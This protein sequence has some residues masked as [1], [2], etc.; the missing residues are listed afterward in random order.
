MIAKQSVKRFVVETARDKLEFDPKTG[1]LVSFRAKAVPDQELVQVEEEDPVFVIQ[2]LDEDKRFRQISSQQAEEIDVDCEHHTSEEIR[3][4]EL[5]AKFRNLKRLNI[6]VTVKVQTSSNDRFS[7]WSLSLT[8]KS[9]LLIT[10][11]QFPFIVVPYKLRGTPCSETLLWPFNVGQLLKNPQPEDLE[12]DSPHAWQFR[13]ENGDSDH[14]PGLTFAQFLAYFNDRGGIYISCQDSSGRIKLI[15]PVHHGRGLRLGIAHVGDWPTNGERQ[16]EYKVVLGSFSGDWYDA[17]TLYRDWSL[18]QPWAQ[19]PLHLRE[20]VP[21]WLLDSPPHIILRIQGKLDAGPT[22]PNEEFFPY[23]KAIPLL[24]KV[25]SRLKAPLVPVIMSWENPGPWIYPESLPPVGGEE[26]LREFTELARER[27]WHI[28]T[29]CNGTRWV[30][31]HYWS[32]YDGR[33]YFKE[34]DGKRSICR[35]HSGEAWEGRWDKDWRPSYPC[36]LGIPITQKIARDFVGKLIEIGLDWIQF[37]DQNVGC[38]TF[39]CYATDHNHPS[40]PGKWMTEEMHNLIDTFHELATAE[41]K[42]TQG[43]R[44]IVFSVE[45]P[46]NECFLPCFQ[47]CDIRVVPPGHRGRQL[48]HFIPL[49]HFLYHEFILIQGG[50]GSAPEPYHM[51]IR[52]A[53]NLVVGE[54]PGAVL[55]GDGRLLNKDT[56]NWAPWNPQVG[57]NDDALQ[58]LTAAT[59]LRRGKGKDFLV[60]GRMLRPANVQNIKTICWQEGGYDHQ[61]PAVFHATWQAPDARVGLILVNWTTEAQKVRIIDERLGDKVLESV[62]SDNLKSRVLSSVDGSFKMVLPG[63]SCVLLESLNN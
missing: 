37:L 57:N 53:Y 10:D 36:C 16:L 9:E 20:D 50:F 40:F 61:I 26:S 47:I 44:Q 33:D 45:C 22:E 46:V 34:N 29:F 63:L 27:G 51:P 54:I 31:G 35:T 17:A 28:G 39:P 14:Y 48:S 6:D 43:S 25:A 42:R 8:N 58:M 21:N 4:S 24:E 59:A 11:V 1:R 23:R 12:P 2:Y 13:P 15:K 49:Y 62:S 41:H 3:K 5:I 56:M 38:C 32:G 19:T 7:H 52:N 18:K 60:Y 55:K 30:T